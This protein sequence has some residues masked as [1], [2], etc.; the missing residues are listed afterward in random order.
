MKIQYPGV[1]RSIESDVDNLMRLISYTNVLPKGLYVDSAAKVRALA[2]PSVC[3]C[4]NNPPPLPGFQQCFYHWAAHGMPG[5]SSASASRLNL[6]CGTF[7][8]TDQHRP[9]PDV[10]LFMHSSEAVK[11]WKVRRWPKKSW[12]WSATTPTRRAA[13]LSSGSLSWPTQTLPCMCAC[14]MWSLSSARRAC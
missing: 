9:L 13:R 6:S 14:P 5:Q 7:Y 2:S 8:M 3:S 11:I 1:A 4:L 12:R 10:Q